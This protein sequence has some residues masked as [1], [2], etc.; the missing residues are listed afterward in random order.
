[1]AAL[2]F[3]VGTENEHSSALSTVEQKA[4]SLLDVA[5]VHLMSA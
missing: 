5:I 2:E 4:F 3:C 1:V